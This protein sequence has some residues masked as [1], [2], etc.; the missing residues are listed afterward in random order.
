MSS[1]EP[2][3]FVC[4]ACHGSINLKN[5]GKYIDCPHCGTVVYCG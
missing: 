3:S 4:W 5:M 2:D 1:A